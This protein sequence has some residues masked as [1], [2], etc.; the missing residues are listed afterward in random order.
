MIMGLSSSALGLS[1]ARNQA[2]FSVDKRSATAV[3]ARGRGFHE[4]SVALAVAMMSRPVGPE[5]IPRPVVEWKECILRERT[6]GTLLSPGVVRDRIGIK[7][8]TNVVV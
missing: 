3:A 1:P 6:H 8:A 7:A 2:R 4:P 5:E